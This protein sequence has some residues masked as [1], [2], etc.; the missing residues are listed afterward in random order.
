MLE[1]GRVLGRRYEILEEIGSG[2]MAIVYKARD[3]KLSRLVAIKVLKQEFSLDETILGKFKKEALA[4]GSLTHPNIVAVY[5]LGHE[6]GCDYI[7]MEYIDGITLKEY[8]KR[9]DVLSSEEVVK[10]SIKIAEA[11][12]VAHAGGIIHRDIKPQNIMVTPSGD[13]KVTDFGIAKAASST[14]VTSTGETLGSVHYLSP[15]Q[16]RGG[17]VDA[18][19]DLYSLGITMYEMATKELPFTAETPVAVAMKQIHENFPDPAAKAPQLWPGLRDIILKLTQKIPEWRYQSA[20]EL[21]RD[22]KHLYRNRNY[23]L[24]ND[25]KAASEFGRSQDQIRQEQERERQRIAREREE[26]MRRLKRRRNT[27]ITLAVLGI[28]IL[29]A[30]LYLLKLVLDRMGNGT[31]Q[32]AQESSSVVEISSSSATVEE[33]S[34]QESSAQESSQ[35]AVP[36]QQGIPVPDFVGQDFETANEAARDLGF[37]TNVV[38]SNSE[39]YETGIVMNQEPAYGTEGLEGDTITLYVSL[40]PAQQLSTV[41]DL[42]GYTQEEAEAMLQEAGLVIGEVTQDYSSIA[43]AGRVIA[44]GTAEGSEVAKGTSVDITISIGPNET[45]QEETSTGPAGTVSISQPFA[46]AE[47]NGKLTVIAID[48][49]GSQTT[50]YEN[51]VSYSTFSSLGGAIKVGYPAGTVR[52]EVYLDDKLIMSEDING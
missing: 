40:G 10:I 13:V 26:R 47:E 7:V 27:I 20:D 49:S 51:T 31:G 36:V 16:A 12:K 2:G 6:I 45:V 21:I 34:V 22:M 37:Y 35:E 15:E 28:L 41:P 50:I 38:T 39:E 33:I 14:T 8:I 19:S 52:V 1:A 4:A 46:K 25:N 29:L 32:I 18:R 17:E 11:L 30:L 42:Y 48:G 43:P 3:Y 23:R 9:R 44:Q 5:D 24:R